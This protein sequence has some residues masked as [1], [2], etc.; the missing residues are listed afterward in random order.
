MV[1]LTHHYNHDVVMAFTGDLLYMVDQPV[2]TQT[3]IDDAVKRVQKSNPSAKVLIAPPVSKG[4]RGA[5][6][7]GGGTKKWSK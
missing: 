4:T 3:M 6:G 5:S 1:Y 7:E 2:P